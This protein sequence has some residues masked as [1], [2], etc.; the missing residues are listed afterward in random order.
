MDDCIFCKIV[1]GDVPASK[2]YEDADILAF[3]TIEAINPGHTLVIPKRHIES[4]WDME[5]DLY[6]KNMEV[7]KKI[8]VALDDAFNPEK[9]GIMVS[10]WDVPHAHTHVIPQTERG[11]ITSRKNIENTLHKFDKDTLDQHANKIKQSLN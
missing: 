6:A 10:G 5:D 4:V 2:V 7:V 3:L 1:A 11:D 9:V 8:S